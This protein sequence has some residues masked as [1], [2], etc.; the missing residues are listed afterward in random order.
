MG[1]NWL[2]IWF[3]LKSF[4]YWYWESNFSSIL[5]YLKAGI[6]AF[7]KKISKLTSAQQPSVGPF[8]PVIM[9]I[10]NFTEEIFWNVCK[11]NISNSCR[12]R[13]MKMQS[14]FSMASKK[15]KKLVAVR[16]HDEEQIWIQ[17][18][19]ETI[20]SRLCMQISMTLENTKARQ[21]VRHKLRECKSHPFCTLCESGVRN[22]FVTLSILTFYQ[23]M[24]CCFFKSF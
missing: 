22:S 17:S 15:T 21:E 6:A 9:L 4:A 11:H 23:G 19:G 12:L 16:I 1:Q 10:Y 7:V 13:E 8:N 5:Y 14:G 20:F 3:D 24:M 18:S 2:L